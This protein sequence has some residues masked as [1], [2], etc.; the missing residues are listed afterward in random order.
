VDQPRARIL[1][2]A[3]APVAGAA[4]TR[5]EPLLGPA[6]CA[7]LQAALVA[8]TVATAAALGPVSVA[9]T[10]PAALVAPLV[11]AGVELFRQRDGD[12]GVRMAAAVEQVRARDARATPTSWARDGDA[13]A[14][15]GP[16]V[17]RGTDSPH[18]TAHATASSP[19]L[20]PLGATHATAASQLRATH[21]AAEAVIVVGTDCPQLG[22]TH[23]RAALAA[24]AAGA[25]AVFGP[26]RDGGYY[27]VALAPT[28]PA[29]PVFAL[30]PAA[31]GGPQVL[32]LSRTA[33][34]RAG[35]RVALLDV[36]HDLDTPADAARAR[37]DPRVPATIAALLRPPVPGTS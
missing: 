10:G 4:K 37:A 34:G 5:L 25:D 19:D 16:A 9:V 17:V 11:P 7:R 35:L 23:V 13:T 1:V 12:L 27:L 36:E 22:A 24:L 3:R 31:W 6:G 18:G 26:A 32:A 14:G 15:T 33:A 8:H 21:V 30:P 28:T 2:M 29:A 20:R